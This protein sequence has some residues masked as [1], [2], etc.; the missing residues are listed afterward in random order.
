MPDAETVLVVDDHAA[1]LAA[2]T[3][4]LRQ[5]GYAPLEAVNGRL[6]LEIVH[7]QRP[8]LVLLD[9]GLPDMSGR[10]VLRDIR[11][12]PALAGVS[13]VLVSAV[14]TSPAEQAAGLDDGADGYIARPIANT[15]LLAR[16][17]LHLRQREL[18]SELRASEARYRALFEYAPDGILIADPSG[19]YLDANAAMGALLGYTSRELV[20]MQAADI[21]VP[22]EVEHVEPALDVITGG[23]PYQ[24]EWTFLRKD[25]T[26]FPADVRVTVMPD[27]NLLAMVRDL[28]ERKR[29]EQQVMHAQRME[30]IGTLA[31]GIA[32][33]LNNVFGP[34]I[35]SLDLLG[36]RY[37]DDDSRDLL[38]I[39]S[40]TAQ[41]GA[42]LVRQVQ[43]LAQGVE[44]RRVDVQFNDILTT[45]D[46]IATEAF[47][48]HIEVR[49][50]GSADL[51]PVVG[52]PGQLQQMVMNLC[53]NARDAMP[54]GGVLRL[55]A[56]NVMLDTHYVVQNP[57]ARPGPY[58]VL[59]VEDNGTGMAADMLDGIFD[60]FFTTKEPGSG[61]GLGLTTALA[62]VRS[63]GGFMRVYSELARGTTF[64]V[65]LPALPAADTDEQTPPHDLPRG[66]GELIMVV[67]D[68]AAVRQITSQTLEA[69]GYRVVLAS[70]GAD[71]VALFAS[72]HNEVDVVLTDMMMPV[73][74][75]P[76]TI[77]VLKRIRPTIPIIAASGLAA[78]SHVDRAK[79]L[80]VVH[81]LPKPYTSSTLLHV[82]RAVLASD[83]S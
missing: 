81:F 23:G 11:S 75:G 41:R 9:V 64:K 70:D 2:T 50:S 48:K 71:A 62:I 24:R 8:A 77:Q 49:T 44:G 17:R 82:L 72:T 25:G 33:D 10:D 80:G 39:V 52:D 40:T 73:M 21:V 63:H 56:E 36:M 27:G 22:A 34:I 32:H 14:Q 3:R 7:G 46:T 43:S 26:T 60:P 38:D 12:D 58:V 35:M 53:V 4:V 47:P 16:V 45:V 20:G 30:S 28:T 76:S 59:H 65:Y 57:E 68:E 29:I 55:R 13:V 61:T 15:E 51:W 78:E 31:A 69:F 19:V 66:N 74:D 67:D 83:A 6:A 1:T 5:A 42:D 54:D 37:V 18:T 79:S